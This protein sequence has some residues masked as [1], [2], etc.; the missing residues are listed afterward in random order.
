M[1]GAAAAGRGTA[2]APAAASQLQ[3]LNVGV[4]FTRRG[5][6]QTVVDAVDL[7]VLRGSFVALTGASGSG[8]SLLLELAAGL[9]QPSWG[10]VRFLGVGLDSLPEARLAQLR[11][12]KMGMLFRNHQLIETLSVGDN[13]ALALMLQDVP[14]SK[15]LGRAE[16]LLERLGLAPHRDDF[17]ADLSQ[18]QR[19]R[20]VV[21][22]A[23]VN[24][25]QLLLA[26]EPTAE[27]DSVAADDVMRLLAE[28]VDEEGLTV[29]LATHDARAAA[30]A[31]EAY[32]LVNG[33]LESA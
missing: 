5:V 16:R 27:L 13:V 29:L 2:T 20:L 4:S 28:L 17:P 19:H 11:L 22:R 24:Q 12:T 18:G 1:L 30:Y 10:S 32:R 7:T 15:A 3:F 21:A 31:H 8:K 14:R 23:L 26:D 6:T 25:P 33:R 9:R